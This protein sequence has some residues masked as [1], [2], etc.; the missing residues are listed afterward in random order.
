MK[1]DAMVL[2]GGDGAVID[3]DAPFKGMVPI[4]GKPMIE[5]VVDALRASETIA[6]VAVVVPTAESLGSWADKV[7]KLVISDADFIDNTIAGLSALNS[8]RHVYCATGDIPALTAAAV[9]D[10]VYR[11]LQT[12]ADITYPLV[13]AEE[14]ARQFPGSERTFVKVDGVKVTGGNCM[15][16]APGIVQ[17][18]RDIGQR[19]FDTR[20]SIF[21]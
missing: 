2:G 16:L 7:D 6:E 14:M 20:K 8:G 1:V 4:A 17:R 9:N 5:W 21:Q 18:N 10:F 15:L 12:G 19:L 13:R 3:P 11:S